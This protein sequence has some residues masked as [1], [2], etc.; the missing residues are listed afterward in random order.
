MK[1]DL[2]NRERNDRIARKVAQ[3]LLRRQQLIA[4]ALNRRTVHYSRKHKILLLI[5]LCLLMGGLNM[6]LLL[7][8]LFG[9]R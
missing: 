1:P 8:G 6:Y 5:F 2:G 7:T 4:D 3:G 9:P